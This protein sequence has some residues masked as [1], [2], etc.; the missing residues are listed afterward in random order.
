MVRLVACCQRSGRV[1]RHGQPGESAA[2]VDICPDD[3]DP[4]PALLQTADGDLTGVVI[5]L[6]RSKRSD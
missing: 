1:R 4:P 5:A 2:F 6:S 3:G